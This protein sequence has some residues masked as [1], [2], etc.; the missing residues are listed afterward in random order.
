MFN[1]K[2]FIFC[3]ILVQSNLCRATTPGTPFKW[4]L[5]RGGRYSEVAPKDEIFFRFPYPTGSKRRRSQMIAVAKIIILTVEAASC[6]H[7]R[8]EIN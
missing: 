8:K 4:P 3:S 2:L 6:D 5:F 7:F 1:Y